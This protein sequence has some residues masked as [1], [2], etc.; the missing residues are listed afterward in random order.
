M[1][2]LIRVKKLEMEKIKN[3]K[4]IKLGH[5]KITQINKHLRHDPNPT[6]WFTGLLFKGVPKSNV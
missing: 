6:P 3:E 4:V 2:D 1:S 5:L